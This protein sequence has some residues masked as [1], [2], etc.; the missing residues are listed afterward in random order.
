M[1]APGYTM[2]YAT[3][4]RA[5]P[6]YA[7]PEML[8]GD[9]PNLVELRKS[10]KID[11]YAAASVIFELACGLP[12]FELEGRAG[13]SLYRIKMDEPPRPL[14]AA[15]HAA[16][17]LGDV[18]MFEPEVAA[19]ATEASLDVTDAHDELEFKRALDRVDGQLAELLAP[20]VEPDQEARP[21]AEALRDALS[22]FCAR[23]AQ[24]VRRALRGERL[25]PCRGEVRR[26]EG[27]SPYAVNRLIGVVGMAL[28]GAA[29][30]T[31]ICVT[32]LL[33]DGVTVL[34][35]FGSFAARGEVPAV[36]VGLTLAFPAVCALAGR[37]RAGGTRAGFVRGTL[38][39]AAGSAL[40]LALVSHVSF[41]GVIGRSPLLA[42]LFLAVAA[43]WCPLVLEYAI[44][45]LPRPFGAPVAGLPHMAAQRSIMGEGP[46]AHA[47][48][49]EDTEVP[50]AAEA[51]E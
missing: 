3:L 30:V 28:S 39:L 24:N 21:S 8:T 26:R 27:R 2:R 20:A 12:P 23:Y 36:L 49:P 34:F 17:H 45:A 35:R 32:A 9:L 6:D 44:T 5:T 18:L 19:V 22:A 51:R 4:R 42:A 1:G 14:V 50:D 47:S 29:L 41:L 38:A 40:V 16:F 46:D 10:E 7:P 13:E 43:A 25:I 33:L 37:A 15:H 11:V 31:V 48:L